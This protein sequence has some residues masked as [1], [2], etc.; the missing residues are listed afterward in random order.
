MRVYDCIYEILFY[1][2][3]DHY[4]GCNEEADLDKVSHIVGASILEDYDNELGS[5]CVYRVTREIDD[6]PYC[7]NYNREHKE[8]IREITLN[9]NK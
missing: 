6:T 2:C 7:L 1:D 4:L 8:L 9:E 3:E 5:I